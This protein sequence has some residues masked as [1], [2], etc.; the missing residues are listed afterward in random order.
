M[1]MRDE[2]WILYNNQRQPAQLLDQEEAPLKHFPKLNLHQKKVVVTVW[3][4]V[5]QLIHYNFLNPGETIISGKYAQQMDE[6][7]QKLQGLQLALVN[8]CCCC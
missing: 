6:M 7:H 2:K 3:W 4:S 5:A 8:C 1:V